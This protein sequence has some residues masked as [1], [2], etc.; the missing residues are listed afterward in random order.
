MKQFIVSSKKLIHFSFIFT[1]SLF[2][3]SCSKKSGQP[4]DLGPVTL[5][6]PSEWTSTPPTSMMRKA[7]F[8]L[9][10]AEGDGE[11]GELVIFYFQGEGG[12]V[13]ANFRRWAG[14]FAQP[15]STPSFD[16][17]TTANTTVDGMP[18]ST[19]ELS[20]TYVAPITPM[21]PSKRHNKPNFRLLG[22]VL[23]TSNGPYFFK[24]TGPEKTIEK[25]AGAFDEFLKSAKRK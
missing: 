25:W 14:Q 3:Y 20:G 4:L 11:D 22:A 2:L 10:R 19:M 1:I 16:K 17:A 15:D 7:Q 18:L 21:D 23:E 13:D 24:L 6:A 12:G 8:T 5:Q 9:P